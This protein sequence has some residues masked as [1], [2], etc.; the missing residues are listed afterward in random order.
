MGIRAR[1]TIETSAGPVTWAFT[2]RTGGASAAPFAG[3][4]LAGH[5]GDDPVAVAR[6]RADLAADLGVPA[7]QVMEQIHGAEVR[8][9]GVEPTAAVPADPPPAADALVSDSPGIGLV[10]QVADCVPVLLADVAA[11][12]IA[13]VHSGWRGIVAGIVP[14]ALQA[15]AAA[16]PTTLRAWIGPAICPLC[17]EVGDDVRAQVAAAAPAAAAVTRSGT[18]AVDVAAGVREQLLDRGLRDDAIVQIPGCTAED[19]DLYSYR[20]DG[21]TGRQAGVIARLPDPGD[22]SPGRRE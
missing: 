5:T 10:T 7:L 16:E 22:R 21:V 15:M 13:A 3:D 18:A 12:R 11:G 6:N 2:D 1:G 20:R 19:P 14:A 9:V 8:W 4:N 17:Y